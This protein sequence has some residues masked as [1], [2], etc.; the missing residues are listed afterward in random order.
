MARS[1][2]SKQQMKEHDRERSKEPKRRQQSNDSA[3]KRWAEDPEV[4]RRGREA[5]AA[6][7]NEHKEEN[8]DYRAAWAKEDRESH[9]EQYAAYEF[10]ARLKKYNA[11][12]EWYRNRLIEQRGTCAICN[13][14][15]YFRGKLQSLSVDHDHDCCDTKA[16]SCGECNRGLLCTDCNMRL[17]PLEAILKDSDIM[18]TEGTWT[19]KA[20]DYLW[21]HKKF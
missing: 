15:S 19:D 4:R 6:W 20:M 14:L 11:T 9:R 2:A 12:V 18:P 8:N 10:A 7:V 1:E 21:Y 13:H 17:A 3:R 5:T 16:K